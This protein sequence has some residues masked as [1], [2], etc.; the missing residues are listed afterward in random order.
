MLGR[1]VQEGHGQVNECYSTLEEAKSKCIAAGDCK[2]IATQSNV[3][4]GKFRVTHGGPTFVK[5]E[6][7]K[8]YDLKAWEYLCTKGNENSSTS[9]KLGMNIRL[10]NTVSKNI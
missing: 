10:K 7:W 3:C 5:Y 1:Y 6:N 4:G 2:A 8:Q 9:Q